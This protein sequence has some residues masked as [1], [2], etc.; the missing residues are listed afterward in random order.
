MTLSRWIAGLSA[1]LFLPPTLGVCA[2]ADAPKTPAT[3]TPG[4]FVHARE[5]TGSGIDG[6]LCRFSI[7]RE[8]YGGLIQSQNRDLAVFNAAGELVPFIVVP[9]PEVSR[10]PPARTDLSVPFF[11]LPQEADGG[12]ETAAPMDVYVRTG[13]GGQ[14]VEV[15]GGGTRAGASDRNYLLDLAAVPPDGDAYRL[16][17]AVPGDE[18]LNARIDVLQSANLRDWDTL[19]HDMPL[20]RLRQGEARLA[21]DGID[22]P[23]SP[24]R[25]L[26]LRIHGADPA[27]TLTDAHLSFLV[28]SGV[29]VDENAEFDGTPTADR[30]AVEYD[31]GGAFPITRLHFLLQEPGL[32]RARCSS[33]PDA[34]TPWRT[35]GVTELF[36]I[37][38]SETSSR[39]NAPVD[40]GVHEDRYW[41][42]DFE[43]SL[44]APPPQLRIGWN[45]GTVYFLAQGKGP[46]IL[47]FGGLR[48]DMAPQSPHL[49]R[50]E[51]LL[52]GAVEAGLG[53]PLD[54][55]AL[56][57]SASGN[58]GARQDRRGLEGSEWQ[59]RLVWML[60]VLGGLLL[61]GMAWRLLRSTRP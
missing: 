56:A 54:P 3:A 41:R 26:L 61:S 24:A 49:L 12:S 57:V 36:R 46:W 44:S 45:A 16:D 35:V 59:R 43:G 51:Q 34:R 2:A 4:D 14:V 8:V 42:L 25:Y 30:R 20:L 11:E 32:Y 33:R 58:E 18:R 37:R 38:D 50:N 53:A 7:P 15:R 9:G 28:R 21:S 6:A 55:G 27:F 47:A 1:L 31:V 17:L 19:R 29:S 5:L 23:G 40:T 39:T 52:A 22:L 13:A 10:E 60:L 48:R